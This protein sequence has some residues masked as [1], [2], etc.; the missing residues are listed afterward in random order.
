LDFT[1]QTK[2]PQ[3]DPLYNGWGWEEN[4]L[5][6]FKIAPK[7]PED[8]SQWVDLRGTDEKQDEILGWLDGLC[9]NVNLLLH[10]VEIM[11][12]NG[13]DVPVYPANINKPLG[14]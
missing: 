8:D 12:N 6:N 7:D 11:E 1:R 3:V 4:M 9:G 14:K 13:P 10:V 2:T 5:K